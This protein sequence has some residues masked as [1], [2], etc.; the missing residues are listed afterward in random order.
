MLGNISDHR[1]T[2]VAQTA[3]TV[4]Q[5]IGTTL[6]AGVCAV[7][8]VLLS[9]LLWMATLRVF[10]ASN[11]VLDNTEGLLL[12]VPIVCAGAYWLA[13]FRLRCMKA[14][15]TW[16][17]TFGFSLLYWL[18]LP[19]VLG[20]GLSALQAWHLYNQNAGIPPGNLESPWYLL[21]IV[22]E[23]P[24]LILYAV[25]QAVCTS[26]I[27]LGS[28]LLFAKWDTVRQAHLPGHGWLEFLLVLGCGTITTLL[29]VLVAMYVEG[30]AVFLVAV[31]AAALAGI[32]A[33]TA[34]R[35]LR[36]AGLTAPSS[37]GTARKES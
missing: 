33:W 31:P 26:A 14:F 7:G 12:Y 19:I 5:A 29:T 9:F 37:M 20:V 35:R 15:R 1:T 17:E 24:A 22:G 25:L 28:A 32:A 21:P 36:R 10:G 34:Y 13:L 4:G 27:A 3:T 8:A 23:A 18:V 30:Y 16:L 2:P 6:L 11:E